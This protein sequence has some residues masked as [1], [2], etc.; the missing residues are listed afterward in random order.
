MADVTLTI[1]TGRSVKRVNYRKPSG[2]VELHV[3]K[4]DS[5]EIIVGAPPIIPPPVV[6]PPPVVVPPDYLR[7]FTFDTTADLGDTS[8]TT[9]P[10]IPTDVGTWPGT[11]TKPV[12]D[13][14]ML[15]FD[16]PS[17][18]GSN[19][20]GYWAANFSP[21]YSVQ[22]GENSKFY[23][24]VETIHN[25]AFHDTV[26][27]TIDGKPG[28]FKLFD[29]VAGDY[30][31]HTYGTSANLKIVAETHYGF[32]FPHL[33]GYNVSG[34][35]I[36]FYEKFTD[37]GGNTDFKLQN[38]MPLC[39]Y[40][41]MPPSGV[42]DMVGCVNLVPEVK[43]QWQ[44]EVTLFGRRVLSG[45]SVLDFRCRAWGGVVGQELVLWA[46]WHEGC[47]GYE[48]LRAQDDAGNLLRF[49]KFVVMPYMTEKDA[50]QIHPLC[51]VRYDNVRI[52]KNMIILQG[53]SG[54]ATPPPYV[55]AVGNYVEI[56][57]NT[58]ADV[59][60]VEN[61][62]FQM[63]PVIDN[64][65]QAIY[66][67]D[68]GSYGAL[69][70]W[71]AGHSNQQNGVYA[72]V[73]GTTAAACSFVMLKA[74]T[75]AADV[76]GVGGQGDATGAWADGSPT[77]PHTYDQ[78]VYIPAS[79]YGN[80]KGALCSVRLSAVGT[81]ANTKNRAWFFDLD[82]NAWSVST[83]DIPANAV[84]GSPYGTGVLDPTRSCIWF[85][86]GGFV[87]HL[88]KLDIATKTWTSVAHGNA[89]VNTTQY[90]TGAYCPDLDCIVW[91][92]GETSGG[93]KLLV[94]QP[95]TSTMT[96]DATQS[97]TSPQQ[98]V[99]LQWCPHVSIKKLYGMGY[100]AGTYYPNPIAK[101]LTP[102]VSL[103]GTWTWGSET[104]A[105]QG[106]AGAIGNGSINPKYNNLRWANPLR[107]FVW[108][109]VLSGPV[110]LMR[111]ASAT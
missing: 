66:A 39:L 86:D 38:A 101:T 72:F 36:G 79:I 92:W 52:S 13:N 78:S 11:S 4:T 89:S 58:L 30:P 111:P 77:P 90:L 88:G 31:G 59:G 28:G 37:A 33:Y 83:N 20:A 99:G 41:K 8:G 84:N 109:N 108:A 22:F 19:A 65:T 76:T 49:G 104:F 85:L 93:L 57:T 9:S 74:P 26:L 42:G 107:S 67:S 106:G 35:N 75:A 87:S 53:G 62:L 50:T 24:A 98:V 105:A 60:V 18:S 71:G 32:K 27:R 46:D 95:A 69:I 100:I 73:F 14:G 1:P 3:N 10:T 61:S 40:S 25:Q 55:P 64:W 70:L 82:T 21:D 51:Q 29:V 80:T 97:G 17:Q 102:P 81:G 45:V 2:V 7:S 94:W 16:I 63:Q 54:T 110:N 48:P 15:R 91:W 23:V 34:S 6:T 103:P 5:V 44:L 96:W 68:Y 43:M 12:L 47:D 56:G